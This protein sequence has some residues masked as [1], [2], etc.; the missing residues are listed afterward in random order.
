M[1]T[2]RGLAEGSGGVEMMAITKCVCG[3]KRHTTADL[4]CT[5]AI[6]LKRYG[7]QTDLG[8]NA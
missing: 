1:P 7:P 2:M 8:K 3:S 5:E 6:T 4:V